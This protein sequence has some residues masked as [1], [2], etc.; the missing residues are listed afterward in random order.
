MENAKQTVERLDGRTL[1]AGTH[2][3]LSDS[4]PDFERE[5][6]EEHLEG[7]TASLSPV[8]YLEERLVA[9]IALNL[10]RLARLERWEAWQLE[11]S[12]EDAEVRARYGGR[13]LVD[14][15]DE[16][17][18]LLELYEKAPALMAP[19]P[20]LSPVEVRGH[21]AALE[22]KTPAHVLAPD[23]LED[24]RANA[25]EFLREGEL[26]LALSRGKLPEGMSDEDRSN[27]GFFFQGYF[28][29]RGLKPKKYV[30]AAMGAVP[31]SDDLAA[32]EDYE[33]VW[34]HEMLERT[35]SFALSLK[36]STAESLVMVAATKGSA[37]RRKGETILALALRG[38]QLV[39]RG[40]QAVSIPSEAALDKLQRYETHLERQLYRAMH[41]LEAMQERRAGRAAPLARLELHG[42]P[43]GEAKRK[44]WKGSAN[45]H[46]LYGCSASCSSAFSTF[47][48]FAGRCVVRVKVLRAWEGDKPRAY[49]G[50]VTARGLLDDLDLSAY[51][52]ATSGLSTGS[53]DPGTVYR[54]L[55]GDVRCLDFHTLEIV[56]GIIHEWCGQR[57][58][59][60]DLVTLE[61]REP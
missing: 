17:R 29:E 30:T 8:G 1:S 44:T 6:Y 42:T 34:S 48:K 53:I 56:A 11:A 59:V 7:I 50:R 25:E 37:T 52:V 26:L 5:A 4:V 45:F 18:T 38:E 19:V 14:E 55:R 24:V 13:S 28:K 32:L 40:V 22:H 16:Q 60:A 33:L 39:T 54:F 31:S 3:A 57:V 51:Q 49:R 15:F 46:P 23:M 35:L 2:G 43:G 27:V 12:A 36:G 9:R 10:W 47:R 58:E 21:L 20:T 61:P 41:E